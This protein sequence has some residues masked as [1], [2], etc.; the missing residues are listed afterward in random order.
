[1]KYRPG[2]ITAITYDYMSKSEPYNK[3]EL[4]WLMSVT[5]FIVVGVI[6]ILLVFVGV[7]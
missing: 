5:L 1:M 6:E 2:K 3:S 7:F 4:V